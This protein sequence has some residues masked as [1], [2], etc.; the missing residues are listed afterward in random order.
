MNFVDAVAA[1]KNGECEGIRAEGWNSDNV[2][3]IRAGELKLRQGLHYIP[4]AIDF[5]KD[6]QLVNPKPLTEKREVKRWICLEC[7]T[8]FE[9]HSPTVKAGE[10][11][12]GKRLV[13]L[14]G[15]YDAPVKPKVKRREEISASYDGNA[16]FY[17][18]RN[19]IPK[20]AKIYAEWLEEQS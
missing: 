5:S 4:Y 9:A 14:T 18:S 1:L 13:E 16:N 6:F 3:V 11:C 2:L 8:A 10:C 15:T 19:G 7:E 12:T 20:G 17:L